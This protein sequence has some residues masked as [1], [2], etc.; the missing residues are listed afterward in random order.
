MP[1]LAGMTQGAPNDDVRR[2]LLRRVNYHLY[3]R[4]VEFPAHSIQVVAL[5]HASRGDVPDL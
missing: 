1:M 4:L 3:Y 2:I 5:W